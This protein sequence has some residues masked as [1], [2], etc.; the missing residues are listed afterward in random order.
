MLE[1]LFEITFIKNIRR[2]EVVR[3]RPQS[4]EDEPLEGLIEDPW[5][6]F[7]CSDSQ[8][9]CQVEFEDLKFSLG[10]REV[11]YYVRAIQEPSEAIN[12]G[13]LNCELEGDK[14]SEVK[15]CGYFEELKNYDCLAPAEER[16]W[17]SPIFITFSP[18]SL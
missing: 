5:K 1:K 9:G 16:A 14:C 13:G 6:T 7:E 3:I 10:N 2:I 15:I 4:Y 8:E 12:A 11:V 18:L 17:S